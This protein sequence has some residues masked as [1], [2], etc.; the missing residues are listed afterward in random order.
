MLRKKSLVQKQQN[1]PVFSKKN[2]LKVHRK[3]LENTRP[4]KQVIF[5][6]IPGQ[7]MK[8]VKKYA[9]CEKNPR[10]L[11]RKRKTRRREVY[12]EVYDVIFIQ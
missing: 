3:S 6:H 10:N 2:L 5:L 7:I 4:V 8:T 1:I 11:L 9:N 12:G